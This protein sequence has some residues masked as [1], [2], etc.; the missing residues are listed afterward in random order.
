V[1]EDIIKINY[2]YGLPFPMLMLTFRHGHMAR[3]TLV[4]PVDV[5]TERRERMD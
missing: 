5:W 4:W 1:T 3:F 2:N